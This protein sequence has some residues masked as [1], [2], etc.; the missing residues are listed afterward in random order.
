LTIASAEVG[1]AA[2]A[3]CARTRKRIVATKNEG[4]F[5]QERRRE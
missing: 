4:V 3:E 5:D 2:G 1:G